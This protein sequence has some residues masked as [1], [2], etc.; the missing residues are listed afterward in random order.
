MLD[1]VLEG[2][3]L[4]DGTGVPVRRADVGLAG[5]RIAGIGDLNTA[6]RA[7]PAVPGQRAGQIPLRHS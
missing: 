2:G 1:L 4:I 3:D 5:D 6:A 7:D